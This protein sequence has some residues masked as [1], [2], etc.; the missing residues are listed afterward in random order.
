MDDSPLK[1]FEEIRQKGETSRVTLL[2]YTPGAEVA[3][4]YLNILSDSV[5]VFVSLNILDNKLNEATI[6]IGSDNSITSFVSRYT[7]TPAT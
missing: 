7:L 5:L 1:S 6:S 4:F 2:M 3:T